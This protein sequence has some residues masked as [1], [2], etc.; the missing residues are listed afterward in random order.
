M[1]ANIDFDITDILTD[2][3]GQIP[4]D[5]L[6]N[7]LARQAEARHALE[8]QMRKAQAMLAT[9]R[10]RRD[11]HVKT[12]KEV[13]GQAKRLK[14]EAFKLLLEEKEDLDRKIEAR[15]N[16]RK[17]DAGQ[18]IPDADG[19]GGKSGSDKVLKFL[20]A[21]RHDVQAHIDSLTNPGFHRLPPEILQQ[22]FLHV[23]FSPIRRTKSPETF[24][25]GESYSPTPISAS[26]HGAPLVL[27]RVSRTWRSLAIGMP[28]LW[29]SISVRVTE[30][31]GSE[32]KCRPPLPVL[33]EWIKRSGTRPLVFEILQSAADRVDSL[34]ASP[35]IEPVPDFEGLAESS[36]FE[37]ALKLFLPHYAR[38]QAAR[39][40]T[41]VESDEG[42]FRD[43]PSDASYPLLQDLHIDRD[44]WDPLS[45]PTDVERIVAMLCNSPRLVSIRWGSRWIGPFAQELP[46]GQLHSFR[47]QPII[48]S[49][50]FRDILT[51]SP[52]LRSLV[53]RVYLGVT[54]DNDPENPDAA[55]AQPLHLPNLVELKLAYEGLEINLKTF[56]ATTTMPNL[57]SLTLNAETIGIG[58]HLWPEQEFLSFVHRSG[59]QLEYLVLHNF[60]F[61]EDQ[62]L[63]VLKVVSKTLCYLSIQND[64]QVSGF[65]KDKVLKALEVPYDDH[66]NALLP[67]D[68]DPSPSTTITLP[69]ILCPKL[70]YL[71][72][73]NTIGSTDG[74]VS[75]M[76]ASRRH[77][78]H[79]LGVARLS[80][81][82]VTFSDL[83]E[84][85]R[86]IEMFDTLN[87]E[88][89]WG[90]TYIA[91]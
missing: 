25:V 61:N 71:N 16:A 36:M 57:T 24:S 11:E 49:Q 1:N 74:A 27:T 20:I 18:S 52:Q 40:R 83:N 39:F 65:M 43:L 38:W 6:D 73:W 80:I 22:I 33:E 78:A 28:E 75:D 9:L 86:D 12:Y 4:Q 85:R 7:L 76:V 88:G 8:D 48:S 19:S 17:V 41:M 70:E 10:K 56:L 87:E 34:T 13:S 23:T 46:F 5:H 79:P 66:T 14:E 81:V 58:T 53:V 47:L 54:S 62:V 37:K 45:S 89:Q 55:P 67:A 82:I 72:L 30:E 59:C 64:R 31:I 91:T 90:I 35:S 29:S 51:E 26:Y 42:L 2:A 63:E 44:M 3:Q 69:E 21:R 68:I 32:G 60:D 77:F 50:R 15:Q 84:H